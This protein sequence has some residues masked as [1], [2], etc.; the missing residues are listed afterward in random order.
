MFTNRGTKQKV[1]KKLQA[2]Y[3]YRAHSQEGGGKQIRTG[4][5]RVRHSDGSQMMWWW[6]NYQ[7][8]TWRVKPDTAQKWTTMEENKYI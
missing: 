4:E 1:K 7:D 5:G 3:R 6:Q 2:E 8:Y